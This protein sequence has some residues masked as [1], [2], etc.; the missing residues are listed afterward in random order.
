VIRRART[1]EASLRRRGRPRKGISSP[2]S[3]LGDLSGLE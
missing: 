1:L 2:P 3:L